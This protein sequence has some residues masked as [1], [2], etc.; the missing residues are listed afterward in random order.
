[1]CARPAVTWAAQNR[2]S[3]HQ[4]RLFV[5]FA[6]VDR[7]SAIMSQ[8]NNRTSKLPSKGKYAAQ[9]HRNQAPTTALR[10]EGPRWLYQ[11]VQIHLVQLSRRADSRSCLPL[12]VPLLTMVDWLPKWRKKLGM[13]M[14]EN[15]VG[16]NS[17]NMK[18]NSKLYSANQFFDQKFQNRE[19]HKVQKLF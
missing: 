10:K 17:R 6:G 19:N 4:R 18:P 13:G 8:S 3:I 2:Q 5:F 1:M 7:S 9:S 12:R 11:T 15:R 16:K 14:T